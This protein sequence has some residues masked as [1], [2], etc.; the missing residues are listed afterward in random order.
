MNTHLPLAGLGQGQGTNLP[1]P[2]PGQVLGLGVRWGQSHQMEM[3]MMRVTLPRAA[4][5]HLLLFQGCVVPGLAST[6][7]PFYSLT[8]P[9]FFS[10]TLG[11]F[12][13]V[14]GLAGHH[15]HPC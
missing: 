9:P 10:L 6:S 15:T 1:C 11:L 12:W 3:E 5:L 4:C 2:R 13:L 8:K 7:I 14:L